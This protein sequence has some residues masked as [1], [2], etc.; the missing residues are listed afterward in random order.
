MRTIGSGCTVEL[1]SNL[2]DYR[3]QPGASHLIHCVGET[4]NIKE[5]PRH[6]KHKGA[7]ERW[8]DV[9]CPHMRFIVELETSS[10]EIQSSQLGCR[11][12]DLL[13]LYTHAI[14]NY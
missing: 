2:E 6:A 14:Y 4:S 11:V 7:F 3:F 12:R 13:I 9:R 1:P 10:Q 8:L 5:I